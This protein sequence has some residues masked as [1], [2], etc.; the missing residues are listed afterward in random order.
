MT[1]KASYQESWKKSWVQVTPR[2]SPR[3]ENTRRQARM[4]I[5]FSDGCLRIDGA[6][7]NV[8]KN[9]SEKTLDKVPILAS[10]FIYGPHSIPF[11]SENRVSF[12]SEK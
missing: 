11:P 10:K 9:V 6:S 12:Q 2:T 8:V 3:R 4:M 7:E 5:S 1:L